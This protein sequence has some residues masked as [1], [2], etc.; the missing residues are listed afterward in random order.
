MIEVLHTSV[1]AIGDDWEDDEFTTMTPTA[2]AAVHKIETT[3]LAL[4][5]SIRTPRANVGYSAF[6][7]MALLYKVRPFAMEGTALIDMLEA[8]APWAKTYCTSDAAVIAIPCALVAKA[9]GSVECVPISEQHPLKKTCH[10]V[11]GI[12]IPGT[13]VA[14]N[15]DFTCGFEVFYAKL[16]IAVLATVV[17][18][19]CGLDVM[20]MMLGRPPSQATM[21]EL[22]VAISDY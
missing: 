13:A 7:L 5:R 14:G 11:G 17:D 22:R 6:T 8:F 21:S 15:A 2:V 4:A 19:D 10:Y 18:G 1:I 12:S 16:G 3:L 20:C 9:G